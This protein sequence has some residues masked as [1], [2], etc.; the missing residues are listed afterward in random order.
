[1]R[2]LRGDVGDTFL[3]TPSRIGNENATKITNFLAELVGMM[4]DEVPNK[5]QEEDFIG[6]VKKATLSYKDLSRLSWYAGVSRI[7][8]EEGVHKLVLADDVEIFNYRWPPSIVEITM[9]PDSPTY[10]LR[11]AIYGK[12]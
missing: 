2:Q 8:K 12:R 5:N 7:L 9:N 1:M 6:V 10:E 11:K 4:Y 3:Q